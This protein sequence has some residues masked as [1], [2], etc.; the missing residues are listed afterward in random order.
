MEKFRAAVASEP[1]R[2]IRAMDLPRAIILGAVERDQHVPAEPTEHVKPAIDLPELLDGFGKYRMQKCWRGRVEHG[3]DVVV[4][5]DFGDAEQAGAVGA[6][7]AFLE[8]PLMRQKRRALHEKH[9]EGRHADVGHGIG[10]VR[11]ETLV[12]KPVQTASQ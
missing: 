11:A 2:A 8:V 7:M 9:R 6:A 5:G 12:R 4:G 3:A 1:G 10:R